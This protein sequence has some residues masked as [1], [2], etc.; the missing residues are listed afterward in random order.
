MRRRPRTRSDR[1]RRA[2]CP[3]AAS[4]GGSQPPTQ[5]FGKFDPSPA[6]PD[7]LGGARGICAC[8]RGDRLDPP[9][10]A[11]GDLGLRDS[12]GVA[13]PVDTGRS[14]S[15][16]RGSS[17]RRR[18]R[19]RRRSHSGLRRRHRRYR[20]RKLDEAVRDWEKEGVVA[21][22]RLLDVTEGYWLAPGPSL[23]FD[24]YATAARPAPSRPGQPGS[25]P[26]RS[27]R[28]GFSSPM[29][30]V[31]AVVVA[32]RRMRHR[33]RRPWRIASRSRSPPTRRRPGL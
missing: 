18:R 24:V 7:A 15:P 27:E 16:G 21:Y 4:S 30:V 19:P 6:Q 3:R 28:H 13:P 11:G 26:A 12:V 5:V 32:R 22:F 2:G 23:F 9:V 1:S 20:G 8:S 17:G 25:R 31:R 10:I 33:R 14:R 29:T